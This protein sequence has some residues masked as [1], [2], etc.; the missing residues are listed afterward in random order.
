MEIVTYNFDN[1]K[2][3]GFDYLNY[4]K[5]NDTSGNLLFGANNTD[6]SS[7]GGV[8]I[9]VDTNISGANIILDRPGNTPLQTIERTAGSLKIHHN[10]NS[11]TENVTP[12]FEL[13]PC[14]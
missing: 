9:N 2:I 4:I 10:V 6:N 14:S 12:K 13:I 7:A 11:A 8:D 3:T 1:K 5:I